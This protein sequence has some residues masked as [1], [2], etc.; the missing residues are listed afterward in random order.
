MILRLPS[1]GTEVV[2]VEVHTLAGVQKTT[3][4]AA[5]FKSI[6]IPADTYLV[7][8]YGVQGR[9]RLAHQAYT[10]ELGWSNYHALVHDD[11]KLKAQFMAKLK[12]VKPRP[13]KQRLTG[14]VKPDAEQQPDER[15]SE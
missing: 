7:V 4:D 6:E 14:W 2:R 1:F 12:P 10:P 13:E 9:E 3:S 15:P 5:N 8:V 11:A